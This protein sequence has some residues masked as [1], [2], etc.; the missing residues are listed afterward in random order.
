VSTASTRVTEC[1]VPHCTEPATHHG[2]ACGPHWAEFVEWMRRKAW[3]EANV[4][5]HR[6]DRM[7]PS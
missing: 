6:G 5:N 7:R 3:R 4:P 1:E 2:W